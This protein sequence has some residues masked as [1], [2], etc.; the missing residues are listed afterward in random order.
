MKILAYI[1]LAV[2]ICMALAAA[3]REGLLDECP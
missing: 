2:I 3:S 1:V